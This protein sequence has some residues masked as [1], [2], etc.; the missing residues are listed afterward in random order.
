MLFLALLFVFDRMTYFL[1][2]RIE[3]RL[4][5][6]HQFKKEF[7]RYVADQ[8]FSTLILGTSRTLEAIHPHY[9]KTILHQNAYRE[10]QFGKGPRY[11]HLFYQFYRQQ[12]GPPDVMVYGLDYF[13][14]NIESRT[15]WLYRFTLG[16]KKD[17]LGHISM[18]MEYKRSSDDLIGVVLE[19]LKQLLGET[20]QRQPLRNFVEI[21][22]Y[23]GINFKKS[24]IDPRKPDRFD[25]FRYIEFPGKEGDYFLKLIKECQEDGVEVILVFIPDYHGTNVSNRQ[26]HLFQKNIRTITE[27]FDN[28]SIY[29]YNKMTKFP[30]KKREYFINGGY[31]LTNSHLSKKGA[32]LFNRMLLDDIKR[33]YRG[34]DRKQN[35]RME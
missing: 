13:M 27:P 22:N 19:K 35:H 31:G 11:N 15:R 20:R 18:L 1:I 23:R 34:G 6:D 17:Y 29:N 8:N 10:A 32:A 30:L 3:S 26:R 24:R 12:C 21:Q 28:V 4:L 5:A 7:A 14:F 9:F 16:E 33:H 25:R 2:S